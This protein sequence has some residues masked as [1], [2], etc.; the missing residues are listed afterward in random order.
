MRILIFLSAFEPRSLL[1]H[2]FLAILPS[3]VQ[4]GA[5]RARALAS[6]IRSCARSHQVAGNTA[7]LEAWYMNMIVCLYV[8]LRIIFVVLYINTTTKKWSLLR[9][10]TWI[11]C[12][13]CWIVTV[14][15][16]GNAYNLQRKAAAL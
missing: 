1:Y 3:T 9:S 7:G 13:A 6:L 8:L 2:P 14:F 4:L 15:R 16:A 10:V 11:A 5:P 12:N